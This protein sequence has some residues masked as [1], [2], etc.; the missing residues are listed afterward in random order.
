V[1]ICQECGQEII[2]RYLNGVCVPIHAA[3]GCDK[4]ARKT[5][6][7]QCPKCGG[8]AF[9]V[10]HNGGFF[11]ADAL[12]DPWPKHPCFDTEATSVGVGAVSH[13]AEAASSS[14]IPSIRQEKVSGPSRSGKRSCEVCKQRI[15][16]DRYADHLE[17]HKPKPLRYVKS[18]VAAIVR[19]HQPKLI[20]ESIE[21]KRIRLSRADLL[22]LPQHAIKNDS[23]QNDSAF[24]GVLLFDV[25]SQV[26]L[27]IAYFLF[28]ETSSTNRATFR[29]TE[30][31]PM[32]ANGTSYIITSRGGRAL[33]KKDG[34]FQL[35]VPGKNAGNRW[36]RQVTALKIKR[37]TKRLLGTPPQ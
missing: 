9:Y 16:L 31:D 30:L 12:G 36:I 4:D 15:R 2:F 37:V 35:V 18:A 33:S 26:G 1:S 10:R 6:P 14:A 19:R 20:V 5:R 21:G 24:E 23:L 8:D 32:F 29:W 28:A 17:R 13:S 27:P 22:T 34:P 7:I 3:G 25:L 11:W